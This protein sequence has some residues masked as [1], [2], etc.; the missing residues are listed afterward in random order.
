MKIQNAHIYYL[1]LGLE[2][3]SS[4][5]FC[6]WRAAEAF[7]EDMDEENKFL[8]LMNVWSRAEIHTKGINP[9]FAEDYAILREVAA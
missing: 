4:K 7:S 8:A 9:N 1:Y 6:G 3:V 2:E 5:C